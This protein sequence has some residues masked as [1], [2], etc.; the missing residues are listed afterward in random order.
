M[1]AQFSSFVGRHRDLTEIARLL[2]E[3]RMVTV[4]GSGGAGKTR[5]AIAAATELVEVFDDGVW[6]V[7][8]A[9]VA[10]PTLV[11]HTVAM[12][13]DVQAQPGRPL[14][15]ALSEYLR[16]RNLLLVLDN[17]EHLVDAC[18]DLVDVLLRSC[19][20]LH[21]LS[22]SREALNL[23]GE[24][25]WPVA[26]L[27]APDP[28]ATLRP[29]DL[30]AYESV[31]LFLDRV[32]AVDPGF[33]LTGDKAHDVTEICSLLEGMPLA[34]ELA[35]AR[36]RMLTVHEIAAGL[37]DCFSL[38]V[39]GP[40]TADSRHRTLHGAISW[41]HDLLPEQ[42]Q[43]LFRRLGVFAGGFSALAV[44]EVCA[45]DGLERSVVFSKLSH[46]VDRSLVAAH[47]DGD[48]TRYHLLEVVRQYAHQALVRSGEESIVQARHASFFVTF[49]EEAERGLDGPDQISWLARVARDHD[50][51]RAA[52]AWSLAQDSRSEIGL[53][54][55]G[56]LIA[57]W[58]IRGHLDEGERWLE[59]LVARAATG[60]SEPKAKA[61]IGAAL[62][63]AFQE[64]YQ[65]AEQLATEGL[66]LFR[67]LDN[68]EGV[69][70]AINALGTIAFAGQHTAVSLPDLLKEGRALRPRLTNR[71]LI[72]QTLDL[73]GGVALGS[74]DADRA[75]ILWQQSLD[76]SRQTGNAL[77]EAF[78]V[79]NLGLLAAARGDQERATDLLR[80]G[81]QLGTK[82]D[83]KL[84]IQYCLMGLAKVDATAG[85]LSGPAACGGRRIA[86]E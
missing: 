5:L 6:F 86:W 76:L 7:Q 41:S 79:S 23:T 12:I 35:A 28:T 2:R 62:L 81:L 60:P 61:L 71:R 22:T 20:Q 47:T 3:H 68:T 46:L 80:Q 66:E 85:R 33:E 38:L 17:C 84:I 43:T 83:Y 49:A 30:P 44:E 52:L 18:A 10:D 19:A 29:A 73:E 21:I 16:T 77:G 57:F 34:I 54:L 36:S 72:A 53:R 27:A 40:R 14:T 1:P 51:L 42:E 26:G 67:E 63:A 31:R 82:L 56:S 74:G 8:L 15:D 37:D 64:R 69:A 48:H 11:A 13:L 4:V 78:T 65:T 58:F 9:P 59:Q 24:V 50:N 70:V 45:T 39:K 32:T 25:A 75:A 55:A